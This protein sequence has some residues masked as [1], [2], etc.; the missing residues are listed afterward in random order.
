MS[1]SLPV[2]CSELLA[3]R[4]WGGRRGGEGAGVEGGE[5]KE[6]QKEQKIFSPVVVAEMSTN[7]RGS[8]GEARALVRAAKEAGADAVK[9]QSY[10]AQDLTIRS[11]RPEFLLQHPLWKGRRLFDLYEAGGLDEA[12]HA[13][14][15]KDARERG[16]VLF[17]SVFSETRLRSLESFS[18]FAYKIASAELVDLTLVEAVASTGRGVILSTGMANET[19]IGRAVDVVRKAGNEKIV[20][21][22]CLSAYPAESLSMN[23]RAMDTLR[24]RFGCAVGLSDHTRDER[25]AVL[26]TGLGVCMI[27]K[28]FAIE[29]RKDD[30]DYA[31]SLD[32]EEFSSFVSAVRAAFEMLGGGELR[33][34][35][36]EEA[37]LMFRRSLYV[38]RS[39]RRGERFTRENVRAIRPSAGLEPFHLSRVL[40]CR[41]ARDLEGGLPLSEDMLSDG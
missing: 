1:S 4:L 27:E 17:A 37:S 28:H 41:A 29:R 31:F 36:C 22:H 34:S 18:D 2:S 33:A 39:V 9:I 11:A 26:A 21:L 40:S 38:V 16:I 19:E 12:W 10:E 6:E 5:G 25:A 24:D 13:P 3:E 8:L 32:A 7:H 15:W 23:L 20:L 14:L 30:L 35:S